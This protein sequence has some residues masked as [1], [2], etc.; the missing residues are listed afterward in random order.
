MPW[1]FHERSPVFIQIAD[2][3]RAEILSGRYPPE[4]QIPPV[5]QLAF[6]ASVNPN[7]MQ[8]ALTELENEGLICTRGTVGRFVTSDR[9]ALEQ[10]RRAAHESVMRSLVENA[11]SVGITREELIRFIQKED[12]SV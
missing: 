2:R 9:A 6:E 5:R 1:Q 4:A 8:R 11:L 3:I 7:T 12:T 10:A